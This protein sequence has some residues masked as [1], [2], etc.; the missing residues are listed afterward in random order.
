MERDKE[1]TI[2]SGLVGG[3]EEYEVRQRDKLI[4]FLSFF[5]TREEMMAWL[6]AATEYSARIE[7]LQRD[8]NDLEKEFEVLKTTTDVLIKER[9]FKVRLYNSSS[10][11]FKW[12][13]L[14]AGFTASVLTFL[15]WLQQGGL[16]K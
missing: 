15:N 9:D 16:P 12:F 7:N 8:L 3:R 6:L 13:A 4:S 5:R 10:A 14:L 1:H 11:I 2:T